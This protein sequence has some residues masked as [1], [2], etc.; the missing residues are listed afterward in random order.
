MIDFEKSLFENTRSGPLVCAHRG[1]C[2]G[3]IPCNTMAAFSAALEQGADIIELDVIKSKDG[4]LF[5]FHPGKERAHLGRRMPLQSRSASAIKKMHY[6]N[7]DGVKTHYC[8]ERLEDVLLFL[9]GKCYIN[10]DKFRYNIPEITAIIRKCGVEKQVIVKTPVEE[11][12]LGLIEKYAPDFMFVPMIRRVDRVTDSLL[13]RK[14]NYVGAEVLFELDTDPVAQKSYAEEMHGKG[15]VLFKNS[16][17]YNE[18]AVISAGLT[19]DSAVTGSPDENWGR[20]IETGADIIQTDYCL[21][22]K[23][24]LSGRTSEK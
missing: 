14:L 17:V 22:L 13:K 5:V 4:E 21:M 11:R 23:K 7:Y 15:L 10:V 18:R 6:R 2:G 19:D 9:K 1:A 16:I 12:Y 24:Y 3:N 20:L 8:V